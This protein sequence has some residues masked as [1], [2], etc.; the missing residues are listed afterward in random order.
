METPTPSRAN[1]SAHIAASA[2]PPTQRSA[3]T[4]CTFVPSAWRN[5]S[6]INLATP[7]AMFMVCFSSDSRT[8]PRRPSIAGRMPIRGFS[9]TNRFCG[10]LTFKTAADGMDTSSSMYGYQLVSF[11]LDSGNLELLS[12]CIRHQAIHLGPRA[13][14]LR[15]FAAQ[16]GSVQTKN[17]SPALRHHGPL[18]Q[19]YVL[20]RI[21]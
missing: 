7:L 11:E 2:M 4:H 5:F 21:P 8:P 6:A 18:E 10:R 15:R 3:R 17:T 12:G 16:L 9:P 1:F 19:D 20:L 14:K 13:Q